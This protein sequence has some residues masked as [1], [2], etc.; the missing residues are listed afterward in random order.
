MKPA[1]EQSAVTHDNIQINTPTISVLN[2]VDV[3]AETEGTEIQ[4]RTCSSVI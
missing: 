2:N 1:D 3:K 4:Y